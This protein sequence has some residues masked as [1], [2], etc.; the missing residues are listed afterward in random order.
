MKEVAVSTRRRLH[1]TGAAILA[2]LGLAALPSAGALAQSASK[3]NIIIITSDDV[4]WENIGAYHQGLMY[5][6][7]PN[8]DK[9]AAEGMRFTD[10]YQ[11]PSCTAGRANIIT[12]ELPIRTGLTTVGQAGATVGM[13]DEAPTIATA[14]KAQGYATGQ[15]G[16][17]HL[18][19]L[20]RYLP[21]LHGFDEFFGYLYHL[22]AMEDPFWHSYPK[23]LI[24]KIGPRNLLHTFAADADDATVQP[25][26]GKIG[27]Q[28]IEDEGPLPPHPMAG[29]KHNMETVDEDI[30]DYALNFIDKSEKDKKPFFVWLN[31]TR[32]HVISHLSPK[33]SGELTGENQWYL[34]EGVMSQL[35]DVVGSVMDKLKK[36]G[37][38]DNTIVIFNSDNGTENFTWPNGVLPPSAAGK[39][40][41]M[42]GGVRTPMIVR[43][44]GHVPAAKV[45]NGIMSGLDLFPTLLT[46]AGDPTIKQDLLKGKVL[47]DTNFKVHLDGYDQTAM[48]T[49]KGP[50][51]RHE[52]FYFAEGTLGAVRIDD[53]KFRMI[54]QP[55][56]WIGGTIKLDWPVLSN[57]RL[58]PFERMQFLK[59]NTGSFMYISDFYQHEFWRFVFLQKVVAEYAVTFLEYPPMQ[60]GASFNLD[61]VKA[62][63]EARIA[64]MKGKME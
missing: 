36:D 34:E 30:R 33:Y 24:D 63:I 42:E 38:D 47:G 1:F 43:W 59:G 7:T 12:G 6:T 55:D 57:L 51:T 20:N 40:T 25:R 35:D 11:E 26:W 54:D 62:E 45:Q 28:R 2:G 18:G 27:K 5:D 22:D 61:A 31:P 13:P 52:I 9:M 15:F 3:P 44:P 64:A 50:S 60:K 16:K 23:E 21:T 14:L 4:G 48:L 37:I 58:D 17:N 46:L 19:D 49:G 39:G 32:A 56:G 53:W 29:I 8:L 41:V 10:Y